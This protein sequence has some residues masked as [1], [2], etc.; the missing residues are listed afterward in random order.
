MSKNTADRKQE[1]RNSGTGSESQNEAVA[2]LSKATAGM[3]IQNNDVTHDDPAILAG[4]SLGGMDPVAIEAGGAAPMETGAM[5][6]DEFDHLEKAAE[7]LMATW[8]AE[9]D[10]KVL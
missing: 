3:A 7:D 1:A 5:E 8:T 2:A 9:E 10:E 4:G 6:A